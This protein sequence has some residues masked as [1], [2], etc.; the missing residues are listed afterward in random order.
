MGSG[1]KKSISPNIQ[2]KQ[3]VKIHL[4]RTTKSEQFDILIK[5]S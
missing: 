4:K 5:L 3:D 1:I 2:K